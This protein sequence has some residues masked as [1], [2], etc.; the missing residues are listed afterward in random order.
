MFSIK[1]NEFL[2]NKLANL[3][4]TDIVIFGAQFSAL[5][6]KHI[7]NEI[8]PAMNEIRKIFFGMLIDIMNTPIRTEGLSTTTVV[9]S[10]I[11]CTTTVEPAK[12]GVIYKNQ[13]ITL[14]A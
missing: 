4:D 10:R 14:G 12:P 3:I 8:S 9:T 11:G 1:N 2:Q 7:K 6:V 5:K 13:G